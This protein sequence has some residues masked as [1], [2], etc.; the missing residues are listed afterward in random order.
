MIGIE[1]LAFE[2]PSRLV[3]IGELD[4]VKALTPAKRKVLDQ[5]LIGMETIGIDSRDSVELASAAGMAAIEKAGLMPSEIDVIIN[6]QSRAPAYLMSS[7]ATRIQ[8]LVGARS[9]FAFSVTDLGCANASNAILV[10]RSLLLSN[11]SYRHILV[12]TGIKPFGDVRYREAVTINGDAGMGLVLGRDTPSHRILDVELMTDGKYWDLFKVDYRGKQTAELI[13][14]CTSERYKFE[15]AIASRNNYTAINKR[16]KERNPGRE[17]RAVIMQNLSLQAFKYNE[18]A[19]A[20]KFTNSCRD[21]CAR[22]G[23]L[24]SIDVLLNYENAVKN[25]EAKAGDCVLIQNNSP[26]A[27]WSSMLVEV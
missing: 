22:F 26:A 17:P 24:G 13:E 14:A 18:E 3:A 25:G 20:T 15:L 4:E 8:E 5:T 19:L 11:P 2:L 1:S 6:I 7:E 27:C 12:T 9:A 23:H 21:N 16:L 10:A